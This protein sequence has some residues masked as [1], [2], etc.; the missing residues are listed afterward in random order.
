M[1]KKVFIS[2]SSKDHKTAS[3][4]C[5]AL[6]TRGHP[7][8]MSARDVK[9]GENFQGAIVR[10]IRDAGVMVMIFSSN[11]NNSDEIKKEMAL[12]SQCKLM[13][14]PVRSEDVLPSEDFTYE[15]AT[16][17]WIDLFDD[18]EQAMDRVGGQIDAV[19]PR[20]LEPW[21]ACE[22][23]QPAAAKPKP[24][25]PETNRLRVALIFGGVLVVFA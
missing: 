16:R 22:I 18:W 13:V 10:A 6:E 7:C 14:I 4:I 24:P 21:P 23:D 12:A 1:T 3:A 8:W 20:L 5:A 25:A 17:Q 11:A 19:L 9:P 2:C 15:L